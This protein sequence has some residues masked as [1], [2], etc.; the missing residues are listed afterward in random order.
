MK[1]PGT[2]WGEARCVWAANAGL[3]EAPLWLAAEQALY[4]VD[5]AGGRILRYLD[6]GG[7]GESCALPEPVSAL[8][9]MADG[10]LLCTSARAIHALDTRCGDLAALA[11]PEL[12][13]GEIRINDGCAHADGAFWFGTM[14]LGERAA[15]GDFYRLAPDGACERIPAG[16]AITNG[17]AFS[18]DGCFGY[19]VDSLGRRIL[20]APLRDGRLLSAPR[21]FAALA[22]E[23]GYPDGLAVDAEGGIWCACWGAGQLLR[24][25][26]GGRVSAT[27]RLPVSNVT[28]CAFGGRA[29]DRL[30]VTTARKG[31]DAAALAAQ[32]LAGGLFEVAVDYRGLPPRPYRGTAAQAASRSCAF[33]V[34]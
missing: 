6:G 25:D 30:F 20:R 8:A 33:Q 13:G 2:P 27:V 16:F 5:I 11:R 29:L 9:P 14:D 12:P 31:L 7:R 26:A 24:F 18:P 19:F 1:A 4:W 10:R 3:G 15:V 17:P 32:P 22:A 21:P 23:D 34:M 28:K